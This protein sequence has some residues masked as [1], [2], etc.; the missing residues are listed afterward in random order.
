[1]ATVKVGAAGLGQSLG[2]K[3]ESVSASRMTEA[4]PRAMSGGYIVQS[5]QV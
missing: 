3:S 4:K 2:I 1:M 5:D